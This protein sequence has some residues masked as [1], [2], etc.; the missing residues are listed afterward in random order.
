MLYV[1]IY[2][3]MS[4]SHHRFP[5]LPTLRFSEYCPVS[6]LLHSELSP[7]SA[8]LRFFY[9]LR[10]SILAVN[11]PFSHF[12]CGPQ[13]HRTWLFLIWL[14][15]MHYIR[16]KGVSL[17]SAGSVSI[18]RLGNLRFLAIWGWQHCRFLR[19]LPSCQYKNWYEMGKVCF[20]AT[21]TK[22]P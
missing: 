8:N 11:R 3:N 12:V 22:L 19:W 7:V 17:E 13:V 4:D 6:T 15:D 16:G 10:Q 5:V 18:F 2:V 9:F 14:A 1:V 20:Y 21:I